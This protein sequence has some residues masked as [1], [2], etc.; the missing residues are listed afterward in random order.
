MSLARLVVVEL[1]GCL[2][3]SYVVVSELLTRIRG[4][5]GLKSRGMNIDQQAMEFFATSVA[6][7]FVSVPNTKYVLIHAVAVLLHI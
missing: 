6:T 3:L 4:H 7:N 1:G 2:K 5:V